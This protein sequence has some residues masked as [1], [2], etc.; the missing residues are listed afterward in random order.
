MAAFRDFDQWIEQMLDAR[1][2]RAVDAIKLIVNFGGDRREAVANG[3]VE[4]VREKSTGIFLGVATWT[5]TG[6]RQQGASVVGLWGVT[7]LAASWALR[8]ACDA[9]L[10]NLGINRNVTPELA[11]VHFDAMTEFDMEA[12]KHLPQTYQ[13]NLDGLRWKDGSFG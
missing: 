8:A 2:T 10:A 6:E 7:T 12:L 11:M 1:A 5:P 4:I 13:D 9:V 3:G